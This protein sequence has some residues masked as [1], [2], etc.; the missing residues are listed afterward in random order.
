MELINSGV[1]PS[2][3]EWLL[4]E[5]VNDFKY[6]GATLH[7]KNDWLKEIN[8]RMDKAE[9]TFYA[10]SKFFNAKMSRRTKSRL[11]VAII[12]PVLVYWCEAWTTIT[13]TERKLRTFENRV[14]RKIC[15]PILDTHTGV[16]RRRY[17]RELQEMLEIGTIINFIKGQRIQ[18]L[19]HIMRWEENEPLRV[20]L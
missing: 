15:E 8:I 1:V 4:N 6:L 11:Y 7:T 20:A 9:K 14:W 17:N 13:T 19:G 18:W 2:D 12:R 5:K 10:L 3:G 16:W